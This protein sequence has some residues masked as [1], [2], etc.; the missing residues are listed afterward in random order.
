MHGDAEVKKI[1]SELWGGGGRFAGRVIEG[2]TARQAL[3][4]SGVKP[5]FEFSGAASGARIDYIHRRAGETDIYFISSQGERAE[6]VQAT[7]RVAGKAPEL[8]L[9]ETG[10]IRPLPVYAA[11]ADGRTRV[12]LRLPAFGSAIVVFRKPSGRHF[13]SVSGNA[14]VRFAAER[15]ALE[16]AA[17]GRFEVVDETGRK[18][19]V[20]AGPV[21]SPISITGPWTVSFPS[22][23]GAPARAVFDRLECWTKNED[24]GIRY[25]SGTATYEREVEI[26]AEYLA[27]HGRL[28]LDLGD[29]REIAEIHWNDVNL[30]VIWKLPRTV[31][32]SRA[33]KP[34]R[35]RVQ[36]RVT[37]FW[38]N[39]LIGDQHLA[40]DK[41][42]AR[43]NITKFTR[44]SPLRLSGLLGPVVVRRIARSEV[45]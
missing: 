28:E 23:W 7:F 20:D 22:G 6:A 16:T 3:A 14:D 34:G 38:P 10:E 41:R 15:Y 9:A 17:G 19:T 8:W 29:A 35:N 44:E 2:R 12:P 32:I 27:P 26:P 43:T 31:D 36:V 1:A 5:D 37:N 13:V 42:I 25:F 45:K 11:T 24:P 40:E 18:A 21:P 33:A 39:R 4:D 30:G